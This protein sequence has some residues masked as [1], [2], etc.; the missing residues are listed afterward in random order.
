MNFNPSQD[1]YGCGTSIYWTW[2]LRSIAAQNGEECD[3]WNTVHPILKIQEGDDL[4]LRI[5]CTVKSN[6]CKEAF[7]ETEREI[8][9][10]FKKFYKVV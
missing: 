4:R 9:E 5:K 2:Q 10:R 7:P 1:G 3:C 8:T 6:L